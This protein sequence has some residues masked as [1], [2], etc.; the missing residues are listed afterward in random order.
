MVD[1][2]QTWRDTFERKLKRLQDTGEYRVFR[3]IE[4]T[5]G[6]TQDWTVLFEKREIINFCSNDYLSMCTHPKVVDA[7]VSV[8]RSSGVGAGGSRNISGSH[9]VHPGLEDELA[10]L[11]GYDRGLVFTSGYLANYVPLVTLG[12]HLPG[13]IFYSDELNHASM[14]DAMGVVTRDKKL[15]CEKRIFRHND[16]EH[17]AE[18]LAADDPQRP[19]LIAFE[20]LYSMDAD[21]APIQAIC[22]LGM[23][24][25]ALLFLNEVHAVGIYGPQGAGLLVEQGVTA[26]PQIVVGTLGKSFG[27][28]GGYM[29]GDDT[30][31][32]FVRSFGKGFIFTTSLPPSIVA[33]ATA[34]IRHLRESTA[35]RDR[36]WE[37]V[38]L[39]KQMLDDRGIPYDGDS[40]IVPV[41]VADPK[42]NVAVSN[43]LLEE[44]FMVTAV[45]YPTVA[46]GTERLRVTTIPAHSRSDV[47]RFVLA[48]DRLWTEF[49]LPRT[50]H[51]ANQAV[52]A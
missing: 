8:V 34:A 41:M 31:V 51:A 28:I 30:V 1:V 19:K 25:N 52:S 12:T 35:E 27:A 45:N 20:S 24:H 18:L 9:L 33:A 36:M 39:L 15:N 14:I 16:V 49:G 21:R 6:E 2:A 47:E 11:H 7:G 23:K 42:K 17:L 32:D 13:L 43:R 50:K 29:V 48:L 44:G 10:D 40:H 3:T 38:A 26:R 46:R 4:V 37:R 5:N 22:D